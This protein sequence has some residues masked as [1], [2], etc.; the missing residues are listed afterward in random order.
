[1][2][3]L[4]IQLKVCSKC[5]LSLSVER[6]SKHSGCKSKLR[7]RCKSCCSQDAKKRHERITERNKGIDN[8]LNLEFKTCFK[9]KLN[10]PVEK[11]NRSS[12]DRSG[13]QPKCKICD[14]GYYR[15]N[16]VKIIE[17]HNEYAKNKRKVDP[18]F[19]S[20]IN[21]RRATLRLFKMA[22]KR[23]SERTLKI[24][25]VSSYEDALNRLLKT[26]PEGYTLQDFLDGK[27]V[28]DHKIPLAWF[29]LTIES[30]LMEA[31]NINNL[32]LLTAQDNLTK[33]AKYG[34]MPD[35][36]IIIY[37]DWVTTRDIKIN[38]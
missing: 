12:R 26:M 19:K 32:Q 31:G 9:C 11:F 22:R 38:G 3:Q 33:S 28:I 30:E 8:P 29:D 15:D 24:L 6:F 23:K 35:G 20:K 25:G 27:L 10:L 36:S 34:H 17:Q 7:P 18:N 16:R 4:N 14:V 5:E 13:L 37:E 2:D 1:M 21:L